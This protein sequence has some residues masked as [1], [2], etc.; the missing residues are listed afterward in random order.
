VRADCDTKKS[1]SLDIA[2]EEEEEV[3]FGVEMLA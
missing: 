2:P 1:A 3:F